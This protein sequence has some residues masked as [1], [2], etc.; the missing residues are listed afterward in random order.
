MATAG[1][2]GLAALSPLLGIG[3]WPPLYIV[4]TC[5]A[6]AVVFLVS[7]NIALSARSYARHLPLVD[8]HIRDIK[9]AE[10]FRRLKGGECPDAYSLYLRPFK[11]TNDLRLTDPN[12]A[13]RLAQ[14]ADMLRVVAGGGVGRS[15][16]LKR[17]PDMPVTVA[18]DATHLEFEG[19]V[20]AA[21]ATR[22]PL[23]CLGK[24]LEHIGAGRI[25]V[26]DDDWQAAVTT[27]S[28]SAKLIVICPSQQTG[29]LWEIEHLARAELIGRT[30]FVDMPE[31]GYRGGR[32]KQDR[33]WEA[34][35]A[36][37]AKYGYELPNETSDGL[38]LYFGNQKTPLLATRIGK[39]E[40]SRLGDFFDAVV[41]ETS[42]AT[43]SQPGR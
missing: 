2:L 14:A 20:M 40:I 33:E 28:A 23:I 36:V 22:A 4:L 26:P 10:L 11:S 32:W 29:T 6:L 7:L 5:A 19:A 35:A 3:V 17:A 13:E 18:V 9:A 43:Q 25:E 12:E 8:Q 38:F 15:P 1:A 30:V 37:L 42:R 41:A 21:L 34:I 27:L 16:R 24:N 31:G 39:L